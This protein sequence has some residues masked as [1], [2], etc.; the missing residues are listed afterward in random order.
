MPE[1]GNVSRM[2]MKLMSEGTLNSY[3]VQ[4][5]LCRSVLH[6]KVHK[7]IQLGYDPELSC[8]CAAAFIIGIHRAC[9]YARH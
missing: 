9:F 8:V 7:A 3:S 1:F 2:V 6:K 5:S 4:H